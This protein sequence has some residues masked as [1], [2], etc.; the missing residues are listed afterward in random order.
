MDFLSLFFLSGG[1]FLGWALGTNNMSN[2]F[3]TAI[4]T[5]MVSSKK[6]VIIACVFV[7]LGAVISGGGVSGTLKQLGQINT[8]AGAFITA[9]SAALTLYFLTVAGIPVSSTQAIV[10]SIIG[11]SLFAHVKV[12]VN[13]IGEIVFSW[14]ASPF[15][16]AI[17]SFAFIYLVRCYLKANPIPMLYRDAYTRV[18]LVIAGALSAYSL[19]ANNVANVMAPFLKVLT[20]PDIYLWGVTISSAQQLFFIGALSIAAGLCM[21]SKDVI[22]TIGDGLFKMSP[23]E[24]FVVVLAHAIVLFLFSSVSLKEFLQSLHLPSFPLVP[25]SSS[26][27]IVGAV[28]GVS[29]LKKGYGLKKSELIKIATAWVLTPVVAAIIS[30][31]ALFF[32]KNVFGQVVI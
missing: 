24:A 6:A 18:G 2:L 23:I 13:I 21:Y 29:I 20:V 17:F 11:W 4:G 27:A 26:G 7:I 12:N 19:G 32:M 14:I 15:L 8:M 9:T 16:A 10:G 25:L 1:L 22:R 30:F 31:I 5:R 28:I 3:G